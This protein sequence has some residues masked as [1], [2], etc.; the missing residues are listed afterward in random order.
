MYTVLMYIEF[1]TVFF[2]GLRESNCIRLW[3]GWCRTKNKFVGL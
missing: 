3:N 2:F 1:S